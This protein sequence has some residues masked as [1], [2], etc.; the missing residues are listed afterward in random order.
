MSVLP[1]T[2]RS[3]LQRHELARSE[4][5]MAVALVFPAVLL[6]AV[7]MYYPM[8]RTFIQSFF[9]TSMLHPDPQ[10]IGLGNYSS[11]FGDQRFW[12]MF[13]NSLV[14]TFAVVIFQALLGL[15]SA[16]LLNQNLPAKGLMRAI[17]L[18]PWVL[19][20]VVNAILWR[21]MYDPQL[22]LINSILIGS[23]LTTIKT[24]WLAQGSTALLALI[25]AAIWKG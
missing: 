16:L 22:G 20:G 1:G 25:I 3:S 4:R 13:R 17:V 7:L 2:A 24:A 11:L 14:W 18:L 19:P 15:A 12:N 23:K 21:F 8:L 9:D 6:V 10:F 5:R